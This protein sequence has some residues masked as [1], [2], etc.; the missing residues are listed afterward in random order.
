MNTLTRI[1]ILLLLAC[2]LAAAGSAFKV[3]TAEV[4]PDGVLQAG[5]PVTVNAVVDFPTTSGTTFPSDDILQ[6][7]SELDGPRW[8]WAVEIS[9][10]ENT[11]PEGSGKFYKISGFEL[12]YPKESS[13]KL[14]LTLD[15]TTPT[16]GSTQNITVMRIQQLDSSSKV[17]ENEEFSLVR[18]VV[19]PEDVAKSLAQAKA[20][21]GQLRTAIDAHTAQGTNTTEAE[22]KYAEADRLLKTAESG[23]ITAQS[24]AIERATTLI[25]ESRQSLDRSGV[26]ADIDRAAAQI[27]NVDEML[28]FFREN[29]EL[30]NDPRVAAITIKRESADQLLT[31]A[32]DSQ[33]AGNL[34]QARVRANESA[35]KALEAYN[36]S[37]EL[38]SQ[39]ANA[40]TTTSNASAAANG[41]V[42]GLL[43]YVIVI[44]VVAVIAIG[45]ILFQ[46][47]SGWD[48][49]G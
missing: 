20:D 1:A 10:H 4:S 33:A 14:R 46:R 38:R 26:Q 6:L 7:Y 48:E 23:N 24:G 41:G 12:E 30:A 39:Y 19:N 22:G 18:L 37:V 44:A 27:R 40:S 34:N 25:E 2:G 21:L 17:R 5:V 9:G 3:E 8:R 47:R 15:G 32:R 16:V 43:P 36:D 42:G 45:I 28:T 11:K 49:L 31:S 13:V 35:T 29:R